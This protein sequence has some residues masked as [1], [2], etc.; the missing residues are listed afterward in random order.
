MLRLASRPLGSLRSYMTIDDVTWWPYLNTAFSIFA[1]FI[2]VISMLVMSSITT[3]QEPPSFDARLEFVKQF[4]GNRE[5][6]LM[7]FES[8]GLRNMEIVSITIGGILLGDWALDVWDIIKE[9]NA[10]MGSLGS[11]VA[12]DRLDHPTTGTNSIKFWSSS[13]VKE[14]WM[15]LQFVIALTLPCII[16][17][18][19]PPTPKKV[20]ILHACLVYNHITIFALAQFAITDYFDRTFTQRM[21]TLSLTVMF[22]IFRLAYCFCA[23]FEVLLLPIVMLGVITGIYHIIHVCSCYRTLYLK[24]KRDR[25]RYDVPYEHATFLIYTFMVMAG[26]VLNM[27]ITARRF[28][29]YLNFSLHELYVIHSLVIVFALLT[30]LLPVR[31]ARQQTTRAQSKINNTRRLVDNRVAIPLRTMQRALQ[32]LFASSSSSLDVPPRFQQGLMD[33]MTPAQ[34]KTFAEI[35]SACDAA[36]NSLEDVNEAL[37]LTLALDEEGTVLSRDS[38]AYTASHTAPP[39]QPQSQSS[40]IPQPQPQS[41]SQ[42]QPTQQYSPTGPP[43]SK[44]PG[45]GTKWAGNRQLQHP[46]PLRSA[47]KRSTLVPPAQA[48][49]TPIPTQTKSTPI[50]TQTKSTPT[51]TQ[52]APV[53]VAVSVPAIAKVPMSAVP[54]SITAQPVVRPAGVRAPQLSVLNGSRVQSDCPLGLQQ[55]QQL[56]GQWQVV[57]KGKAGRGLGQ[58]RGLAHGTVQGQGKTRWL[59]QMQ[60]QMQTQV[61]VQRAQRPTPYDPTLTKRPTTVLE[62]PVTYWPKTTP[63]LVYAQG[64]GATEKHGQRTAGLLGLLGQQNDLPIAQAA[65]TGMTLLQIPPPLPH[66]RFDD[67]EYDDDSDSYRSGRGGD[68]GDG[69]GDGNSGTDE[70][71]TEY[72]RRTP[73]SEFQSIASILM[74]TIRSSP[75]HHTRQSPLSVSRGS[76]PIASQLMRAFSDNEREQ[77]RRRSR[78]IGSSQQS[79]CSSLSSTTDVGLSRKI[80]ANVSEHPRRFPY[81]ATV[82]DEEAS[83]VGVCGGGGSRNVPSDE[84]CNGND[85]V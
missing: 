78:H 57:D 34:L 58:G 30:A 71:D 77:S 52:T 44:W 9:R 19:T 65:R 75:A 37:T 13:Q 61:Q 76:D 40:S 41:Q 36:L 11:P 33:T 4:P 81:L 6:F 66:L 64:R 46:I 49:S 38:M 42:L 67:D 50:P 55:Q 12:D 3:P 27:A 22:I 20:F 16:Q 29:S 14:A 15:R 45:S 51:P 24:M 2:L 73:T 18:A 32:E 70:L 72:S 23:Y 47:L 5:T 10:M 35:A 82:L 63:V 17:Y 7:N 74:T 25:Y 21:R 83:A 68:G 69:G 62:T 85:N 60:G 54:L 80:R 8:N 1:Q 39:S 28:G 84:T 59:G 43:A 79:E 31:I 26:L 53:S 56:K 48:I